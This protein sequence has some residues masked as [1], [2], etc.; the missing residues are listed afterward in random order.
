MN[1]AHLRVAPVSNIFESWIDYTTGV[2]DA[3]TSALL[4]MNTRDWND[5]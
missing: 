4:A 5:I 1:H 3:M 2:D